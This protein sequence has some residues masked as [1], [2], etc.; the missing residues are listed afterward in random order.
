MQKNNHDIST[1]GPSHLYGTSSAVMNRVSRIYYSIRGMGLPA[2]ISEIRRQLK[3]RK[4]NAN[5]MT[6]PVLKGMDHC[7]WLESLAD[8][9]LRQLQ[10]NYETLARFM[11]DMRYPKFYYRSH[12]R[13]RYALWHFLGTELAHLDRDS[14]VVDVGARPGIWGEMIRRHVGCT[15]YEV[16]LNYKKGIHGFRIG[17]GAESIPLPNESVTHF[18]SFCAFNCFEGSGDT[19][20]LTEATRLLVPGGKIILVPLCIADE[21]VNLYDPQIL[22]DLS[23]LDNEAK[24]IEWP[25][26]GNN[27]GRWYNNEALQERI[28]NH[29]SSFKKT[30]WCVRH[31]ASNEDKPEYLYAAE[32]T[33]TNA[34]K[35]F[36]TS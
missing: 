30:I 3:Y 11:T 9:E 14:V 21:Y 32:F 25:G 22:T 26:W 12:R 31:P 23:R 24:A 28:L 5:S 15:V 29:I 27:F 20:F 18:L 6:G 2:T 10:P 36:P 35:K 13:L 16:D 34:Q 4:Q 1:A 19:D 33:K 8:V 17:S 7:T